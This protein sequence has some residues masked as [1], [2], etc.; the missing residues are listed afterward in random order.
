MVVNRADAMS[1]NHRDHRG[2]RDRGRRCLLSVNSV[3][4]V[5]NQQ[6]SIVVS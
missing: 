3:C 4:S 6:P 2:H 1:V 5:V